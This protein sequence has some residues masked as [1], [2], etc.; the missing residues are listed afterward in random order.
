MY[1]SFTRSTRAVCYNGGTTTRCFT[2]EKGT[3]KAIQYQPIYL[4]LY[5]SEFFS[6]MLENKTIEGVNIFNHTLLFM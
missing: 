5:F 6:K 2:L 3:N 4:L 1:R